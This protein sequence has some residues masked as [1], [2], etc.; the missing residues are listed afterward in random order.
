MERKQDVCYCYLHL[1]TLVLEP[2]LHLPGCQA[3]LCAERAPCWLIWV[4][5]LLVCTDIKSRALKHC[6]TQHKKD[7]KSLGLKDLLVPSGSLNWD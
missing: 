7:I 3:D 5:I 1:G 6:T 4:V 2:V